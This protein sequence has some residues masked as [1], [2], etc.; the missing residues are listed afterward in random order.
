MAYG[1]RG[2]ANPRIA[3]AARRTKRSGS[4]R[5]AGPCPEQ[6]DNRGRRRLV[7]VSGAVSV[8][9]RLGRQASLEPA[10]DGTSGSARVAESGT[11]MAGR[12]QRA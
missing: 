6:T 8:R 4:G 7:S 12:F 5:G 11:G 2:L 1:P 3:P 9:A 10:T